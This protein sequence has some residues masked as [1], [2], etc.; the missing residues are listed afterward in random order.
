MKLTEL[1]DVAVGRRPGNILIKGGR[2]VNV[3]SGE[4]FEADVLIYG[5]RIAAVGK[6]N[7]EAE[8]VIDVEGMLVMPGFIEGHIH[9]ESSM[10][11][12]RRF[13]EAVVVHGTTTVI[14]D[15]HEIANVMGLE[16]IH[17]MINDSKDLPV[18][19]YFMAP[20]CV[21]SSNLETSGAWLTAAELQKLNFEPKVIGLAEMMD[22]PGVIAAKSEVI[23]R[24]ETFE[25]RDGHAPL[26][27]GR[28][29]NAY[30]A[31][32][33]YSDHECVSKAE[34]LEKLRLGMQVMIREGTAAQNLDELIGLVDDKNW[35]F[36]S[37]VS[38]DLHPSTIVERGHLNALVKKAVERGVPL[39]NAI[40]MVSI[41]TARYFR[42]HD[43]GEI[44]PGKLADIVI[45]DELPEIV[46][47]IKSGKMVVENT[48]LITP[49]PPAE[50][51]KVGR[52][53]LEPSLEPLKVPARS[54]E[55]RVIVAR[56]GTLITD[57]M[58]AKPKVLDGLVV[59]DTDRDILKIS[60]WERHK[61]TGNVGVG[62]VHGFGLKSGA[63]ASSVAHDSHNI[64]AIG[65]NDNDMV[66]AVEILK[67]LG[68]GLVVVDGEKITKL[69][70][71][72]AG[73]MTDTDVHELASNEKKLT[74][75]A[76]ALGCAMNNPFMTMSFLALP[77]IPHIKLTDKGLVDVDQFKF[78]SLWL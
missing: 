30:I 15:P 63:I 35:P 78:V 44:V 74:E 21:P 19:I 23:D 73:L 60:V 22:F 75:A 67:E 64:V 24:L 52:M 41:N 13:A 57:L 40:R 72:V 16:G 3:R 8:K 42:L 77:V 55:I 5:D 66:K 10:M 12:P 7:F 54:G 48:E 53:L 26:L 34:A 6:Y 9:I 50:R 61:G 70:L 28:N 1:I 69:P 71:P 2:V 25:L 45:A 49:V 18:D 68:G 17:F 76:K 62:F 29:L 47:V 20:S 56:E 59:S 46:H 32:G 11:T 65:T 43:R 37:L 51:R 31:A 27:S 36:F 4:I 33:I 14:A 58:L 39:V 38:D